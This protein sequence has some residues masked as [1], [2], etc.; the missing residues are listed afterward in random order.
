MAVTL[1]VIFAKKGKYL[2]SNERENI[3]M[4]RHPDLVSFNCDTTLS[5]FLFCQSSV[6]SLYSFCTENLRDILNFSK[7]SIPHLRSYEFCFSGL[8][9]YFYSGALKA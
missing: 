2:L 5:L 3:L 9:Y 6:R 1:S 4:V 7:K 8:T